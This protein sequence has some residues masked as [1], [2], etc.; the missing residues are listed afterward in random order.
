MRRSIR[1]VWVLMA[2]VVAAALM[3]VAP[4]RA[5]EPDTDGPSRTIT[6]TGVGEVSVDPD[7]VT[8]RVGVDIADA[9]LATA[10]ETARTNMDAVMAALSE[11]GIAE[12][13]IA[14][15]NYS[16]FREDRFDPGTSSSVPGYRVINILR[17]TVRDITQ[18]VNVLNTAVDAGA[19]AINSVEFGVAD[20]SAAETQAR[21]LALTNAGARA[22]ELAAAVGGTLGEVISIQETYGYAI[23]LAFDRGM[24]GGGAGPITPGS[25]Q[26]S[27]SL[28]VTY[29]LE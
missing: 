23:P 29:A 5:Q 18:L 20:Q 6:V 9:S 16:V 15:D 28:I 25:L 27:I 10:M 12:A 14:T 19:N 2:I 24:G 7:I 3:F 4:V 1:I 13:D 26:V 17:V 8:I 22:A 11:A 21:Q